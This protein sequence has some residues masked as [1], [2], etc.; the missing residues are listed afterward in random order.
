MLVRA[1]LALLIT[2]AACSDS[3]SK[4]PDAAPSV[5][6]PPPTVMMVTCPGGTVP[7]VTTVD[8]TFSFS[9]SMTMISVGQIVKFAMSRTHDVEPNPTMSD[10]GLSVALGATTCL[11][12]TR[13]G[14][15]GFHCGPHSFLGTI[16]V[17]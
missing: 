6:A 5:D 17:Q 3:T 15:F 13:A 2:L 9:P 10:R 12:F 7:T 4:T 14:T 16:I 8:D 11:M 1:S